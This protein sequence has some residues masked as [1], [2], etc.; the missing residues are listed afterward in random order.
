M[1]IHICQ[2]MFVLVVCSCDW[3]WPYFWISRIGLKQVVDSW[4]SSGSAQSTEGRQPHIFIIYTFL[5]ISQ[6]IS[7]QSVSKKHWSIALVQH[8][9]NAWKMHIALWEF[10]TKKLSWYSGG[11]FG[12]HITKINKIWLSD[13][14]HSVHKQQGMLHLKKK[15]K[16]KRNNGSRAPTSRLE[17]I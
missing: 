13:K 3:S 10:E 8:G 11:L 15:K 5:Y 12:C 16:E 2:C 9:K 6:Y 14:Y 4:I 7:Q 1:Q 17:G